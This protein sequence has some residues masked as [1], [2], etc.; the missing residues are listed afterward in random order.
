M[1]TNI[2]NKH[3]CK[4]IS[5]GMNW[6]LCAHLATECPRAKLLRQY[7]GLKFTPVIVVI[8]I[9]M[10]TI[11][12][13]IAIIIVITTTTIIYYLFDIDSIK[14]SFDLFIFLDQICKNKNLFAC[15]IFVYSF[16]YSNT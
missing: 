1:Q 7:P 9:I 5:L 4:H 12:S 10:A 8:I 3:T 13:I 16:S 15:C 11:T 6:Q 14:D 2:K